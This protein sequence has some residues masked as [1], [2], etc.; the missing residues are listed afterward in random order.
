MWRLAERFR[1]AGSLLRGHGRHIDLAEA[2]VL[3]VLEVQ[4]QKLDAFAAA[5]EPG[6]VALADLRLGLLAVRQMFLLLSAK[7]FMDGAGEAVGS[8][9]E[10]PAMALFD[11]V[12]ESANRRIWRMAIRVLK[13]ALPGCVRVQ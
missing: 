11:V 1:L 13:A 7:G 12:A 10:T 6:Q 2:D 9:V 8:G 5:P 4:P 3:A